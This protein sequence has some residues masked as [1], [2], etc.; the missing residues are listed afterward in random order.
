MAGL[1]GLSD[2]PQTLGLL[3]LGLRL[4]SNPSRRFG[5]ALGQSGLGALSDIQQAQAAQDERKSRAL[6][7]KLLKSQTDAAALGVEEAQRQAELARL[8]AQF[9]RPG[10]TMGADGTDAGAG[11]GGGTTSP[12]QFDRKSYL[13]ALEAKDPM[14]A[15][16]LRAEILAGEKKQRV[17]DFVAQALGGA[18]S[19]LSA[20]NAGTL[21]KTGS[22]A[23]T[24]ENAAVQSGIMGAAPQKAGVGSLP[25]QAVAFDLMTN[26]GKGIAAEL[27]QRD[28]PQFTTM[29]GMVIDQ[30]RVQPGFSVPIGNAQGQFSQI[31]PDPS[32]PGGFRIVT[33]KGAIDAYTGYKSA[34]ALISAGTKTIEKWDPVRQQMVAVPLTEALGLPDPLRGKTADRPPPVDLNAGSQERR[35]I[36]ESKIA[37]ER[38]KPA[39]PTTAA[40]IAALQKE[41]S[42]LPATST[43]AAG[44]PTGPS[45]R[46]KAGAEALGMG[47]KSFMAD[48]YTP[49]LEAGRSA[50][51]ALVSIT[52]ARNALRNLGE[53]GWGTNATVAAAN[54]LGAFGV[55]QAKQY[56]ASAQTFE[57]AAS[58]RL[59]EVLNAAKGPQT[60]GDAQ[61]P[62]AT[63]AQLKDQ[64]QKNLYTLDL[65]Q[66]TA[67]RDQRRAEFYR[68]GLP[69]AQ[70]S[71]DLQELEREW[72]LRAPSVFDMPSMKKWAPK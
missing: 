10:V 58:T 72:S 29:G 1:L 25:P 9:Y 54:V 34:D 55:P 5:A 41:L 35:Q 43:S 44:M 63:F 17:A 39:T 31:I 13:A 53:T 19:G 22:L 47:N 2:D 15:E 33:P 14:A 69:I 11:M 32:S 65:M 28:R 71:G 36:L 70:K 16:R 18:D 30:T 59:W 20:A 68:R 56:A 40:N 62:Q 57:Q 21:A 48:S 8:P 51:N 61:R 42:R 46:E 38:A 6:R 24:K 49:A 7:D 45:V 26:D 60:E 12:G 4:M 23:P 37:R 50:Q 64:T 52:T 67:E 66:A 3:S 27:M